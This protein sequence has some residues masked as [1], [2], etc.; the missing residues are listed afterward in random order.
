MT[1]QDDDRALFLPVVAEVPTATEMT[2]S[3]I[4]AVINL[5]LLAS[6]SAASIRGASSSEHDRMHAAMVSSALD[7]ALAEQRLI[8]SELAHTL[9]IGQ[10]W[11]ESV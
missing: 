5:L 7:E 9:P 11:A 10:D 2:L 4:E 3:R 1:T 6:L 8:W